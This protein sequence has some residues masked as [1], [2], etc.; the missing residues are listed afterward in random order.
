MARER[1]KVRKANW[2]EQFYR[3]S[4]RPFDDRTI[5]YEPALM[6]I[7]RGG[8]SRRVMHHFLRGSNIGLI[9]NRQIMDGPIQHFWLTRNL[10]DLHIIQ[11]AHASAYVLPLY[12]YTIA[13]NNASLFEKKSQG[14]PGD[15]RL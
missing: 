9:V 8:A 6:E 4:Y 2:K 11:T 12:R 13:E 15:L 3:V 5:F 7:G 10:V 14:G 1:D